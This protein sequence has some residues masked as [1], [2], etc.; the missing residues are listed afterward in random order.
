MDD[1]FKTAVSAGLGQA[2]ALTQKRLAD[3]LEII[4]GSY[5]S[6]HRLLYNISKACS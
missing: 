2:D 5:I 1:L 4:A 3:A 6:W